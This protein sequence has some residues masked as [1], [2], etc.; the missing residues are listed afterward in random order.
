MF[1]ITKK[2]WARSPAKIMY[3]NFIINVK[4]GG[5]DTYGN[6]WNEYKRTEWYFRSGYI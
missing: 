6:G 1:Y 2:G 5:G 3:N 4:R